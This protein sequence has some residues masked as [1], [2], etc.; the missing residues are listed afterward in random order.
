MLQRFRG[1]W[2][3]A[4]RAERA[5]PIAEDGKADLR[6]F[7]GSALTDDAIEVPTDA[8]AGIPVTYVPAR[9]TVFLALALAW[10]EVL[11]ANDIAEALNRTEPRTDRLT[12][13]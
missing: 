6:Q 12:S 13:I 9:N 4:L 10:S 11:G 8:P 1:P 2:V 7:G 3:Q 5:R